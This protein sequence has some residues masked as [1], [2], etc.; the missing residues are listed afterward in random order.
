MKIMTVA[1]AKAY[2]DTLTDQDW[3]LCVPVADTITQSMDRQL[4][5]IPDNSEWVEFLPEKVY[6]RLVNQAS[7]LQDIPVMRSAMGAFLKENY[8]GTTIATVALPRVLN[9]L[10]I[11][12][13]K[14]L[15]DRYIEGGIPK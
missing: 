3:V 1:E 11:H 2:L 5:K 10:A 6:E 9:Y 14:E 15:A 4:L 12:G 8:P 13:Q 7:I